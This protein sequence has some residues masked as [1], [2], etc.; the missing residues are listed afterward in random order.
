MNSPTFK[1]SAYDATGKRHARRKADPKDGWPDK[2]DAP[3]PDQA[4]QHWS[5]S[6][7]VDDRIVLETPDVL[8][9]QQTV[10]LREA[11]EQAF[12]GKQIII[13]AGGLRMANL[14]EERLD[15]IEA[16]L[17]ALHALLADEDDEAQADSLSDTQAPTRAPV[18]L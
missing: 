7:M 11:A 17:D 14:S 15:R 13:L 2:A 3:I 6:H 10:A 12:P 8:S 1:P 18:T 4:P 9:D 16:K 5:Q